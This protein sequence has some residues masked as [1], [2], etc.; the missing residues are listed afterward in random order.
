MSDAAGERGSLIVFEGIDGAG[1]ST[2]VARLAEALEARGRR[3]V[4]SAEPTR[5][6]YGAQ[7]RA[8]MAQGRL[9]PQE[10]LDLFILDRRDHVEGLI[11]PALGRGDV[12]ILDRYYFS[13]VAYQGARGFDPAALLALNTD[14]APPPDLLLLL[15]LDPERGLTRI[16]EDRK[17]APDAFEVPELLVRSR[18]IFLDLAAS[19]PGAHVL[20][21]CEDP[22]ALARRIETLAVES[23]KTPSRTMDLAEDDGPR[24]GR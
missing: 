1:K 14:F 24:Q 2:Q 6:R 21:A 12:V 19:T 9:Q 7:L 5:G 20:D 4:R 23:L 13:T 18:R 15:D 3:V 16:R 10:E 11:E 8:S 17:E 22:D